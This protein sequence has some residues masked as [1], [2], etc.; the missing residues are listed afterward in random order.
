MASLTHTC[1]SS[2]RRAWCT[3]F[4]WVGITLAFAFSVVSVIAGQVQ[5]KKKTDEI[6]DL[7]AFREEV[8]SRTQDRVY[9]VEIDTF[10]S[11]LRDSNPELNVPPLPEIAQ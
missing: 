5:S 6:R 7:Q 2:P 10:I 4:L 1:K 8:D 3:F 9:R 11:Q